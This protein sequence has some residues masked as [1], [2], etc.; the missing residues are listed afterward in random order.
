MYVEEKKK[1]DKK[2]RDC[3][4]IP[5]VKGGSVWNSLGG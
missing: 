5:G 2:G 1:V 3:D 4:K